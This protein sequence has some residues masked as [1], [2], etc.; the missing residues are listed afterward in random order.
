MALRRF[1]IEALRPEQENAL[2]AVLEGRD[3]LA[4]LPTGYG[5]SLIYQIAALMQ[6]RPTVVVSPLIALMVDQ[7]RA[8]RAA[9][10]PAIRLDSTLLVRERK[11]ALERLEQGGPLVILTTPETLSSKILGPK[12]AEAKPALLAVDEAHCVSEWGHDFRPAYLRLGER[13]RFLGDP[14]VIATTATATPKV[15]E[16]IVAG[17]KMKDPEVV[18]APPHRDNLILGAAVVP[19]GA[20]PLAAGRLLANLPR[21][22]VIYCSTTVEVDRLYVV[23]AK[24]GIPVDHY[25]GKMRKDD[26]ELNAKRFLKAGRPRVMIATSAFGM[27]IDKRDIRFVIHYQAPGSLEQY[28]QEAG[29]GGRD[30]ED[31]ECIL[32]FDWN[33]LETQR[34]LRK[35]SRPRADQLR[36]V[37]DALLAWHEDGQRVD[38]SDL[39]LS[40]RVPGTNTRT[41]VAR[42]E[43]MGL[44]DE[45]E[46]RCIGLIVDQETYKSEVDMFA[47]RLEVERLQDE[48]RIDDIRKYAE[49]EGCRSTFL[50][51]WFGEDDPPDCGYCDRC[52]GEFVIPKE[53]ELNRPRPKR[54]KRRGRDRERR[55]K[56]G[57]RG[58]E[59][60]PQQQPG[61]EG[62][63]GP[64]KKRRRRRRRRG[65]GRGEGGDGTPAGLEASAVVSESGAGGAGSPEVQRVALPEIAQLTG[66]MPTFVDERGEEEREALR[67]PKTLRRVRKRPSAEE[68]K[69][70]VLGE[71]DEGLAE[72]NLPRVVSRPEP[73]APSPEAAAEPA[74]KAPGPRVYEPVPARKPVQAYHAGDHDD[75]APVDPYAELE[76]PEERSEKDPKKARS[77]GKSKKDKP[78]KDRPKKDAKGNKGGKKRD[79]QDRRDDRKSRDGGKGNN[80]RKK[81][82]N[83]PPDAA[84]LFD[85]ALAH[86]AA[87]RMESAIKSAR[88]ALMV[89]QEFAPARAMLAAWMGAGRKVEEEE[90]RR[91]EAAAEAE[92]AKKKAKKL[93]KKAAAAAPAG[94]TTK[95]D[96]AG[97][98]Q[99]SSTS[100]EKAVV[101]VKPVKKAATKK[102]APKK[103]TTKKAATKKAATKKAAT[104]KATTKKATTKKAA[105]KK[106]TTKKATTKKATTKKATTKKATTKK[107]TTKKATTKKAA[108]KKATKKKATKKAAAE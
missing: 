93:A 98:K 72:A 20:K 54:K 21:P 64:K 14:Q 39:S 15:R 57:E 12:I 99:V 44:V 46:D 80:K 81:R 90:R 84:Q 9:N 3:A 13:R 48:R 92:A 18:V 6:D 43:E 62:E 105:T 85:H 56:R 34:H 1:G 49:H 75:H 88:N 71:G 27:G 96:P 70:T 41:L 103:A 63:D 66:A 108:T 67:G 51:K 5:K 107:A 61:A 52:R 55:K 35:K 11:A 59:R 74:V 7:A 65:K 16:G 91:A 10:I 23:L 24:T 8:M 2:R 25:H 78:K 106:A 76:A 86:A 95:A 83:R 60:Q 31:C 45:D 28:V 102:A 38:A 42:L 40:S 4:V 37:A 87:G 89:D 50:R 94:P 100:E 36:R 104:K 33:D 73:A 79:R 101:E 47:R 26:R 53:G 97:P 19:G 68:L 77:K 29:R 69:A 30:G 82:D 32:L 17:L 58:G 22:G